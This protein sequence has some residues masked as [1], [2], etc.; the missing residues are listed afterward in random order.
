MPISITLTEGVLPAGKEAA[1][2]AKITEA[3]LKHHGL[4]GNKVMTPNITT[5]LNIL[6]KG[7]AFSGGMPIDGAWVETKTPSFALSTREIQTAFFAEATQILFELSEGRLSKDRIWSNGVY[8]ED[9]T[10]NL[11]GLAMT[12]EELGQAIAAG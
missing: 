2:V 3:F 6:P 9:G 11:D 4:S 10:W 12:N 8:A 5:H 7:H 1:A